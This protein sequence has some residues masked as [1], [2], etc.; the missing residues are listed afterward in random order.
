MTREH[1]APDPSAARPPG[2]GRRPGPGGRRRLTRL[3]RGLHR[4]ATLYW[5]PCKGRGPQRGEARAPGQ[6]TPGGARGERGP[7]A[8]GDCKANR[9]RTRSPSC[10]RI[11]PQRRVSIDAPLGR[12]Q[13]PWG[14]PAGRFPDARH[15]HARRARG[16]L[17]RRKRPTPRPPGPPGA[18]GARL[19]TSGP[20]PPRTNIRYP[21]FQPREG[22]PI[23][24]VRPSVGKSIGFPDFGA[25]PGWC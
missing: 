9:T 7:Q 12:A 16:A 4:H 23:S 10:A 19:R 25:G 20:S 24:S 18:S 5:R 14:P 15:S 11:C 22:R 21:R 3:R 6:A 8:R 2:P 13:G 1:P 17:A